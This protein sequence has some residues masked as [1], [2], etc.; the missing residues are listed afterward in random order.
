MNYERIRVK[1]RTAAIGADIDGV[2]LEHLDDITFAEIRRALH[3]H[4]VVFFRG[5]QLSPAGHKAFAARF[6]DMEVHEVFRP[7]DGHPEISVL[8]HDAERPPISDSWHSDVTYRPRPALVS[9]L[10]ARH[11]PPV[12]GDTLWL[13]AV[14]ACEALSPPLRE[15]LATLHAEHDFLQAYGGYFMKQTDGLERIE[16]ARR[17][18][19][20]VTHPVVIEHPVTGR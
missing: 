7:Y 18:T 1:P 9:I 11:I 16:R 3:E 5:Q 15:F 8:E 19:P 4:L 6:G 13:S 2:D 17:E 10:H 12:G 14:A 20:P